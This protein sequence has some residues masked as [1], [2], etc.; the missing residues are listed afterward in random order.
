MIFI[1]L[2]KKIHGES[3]SGGDEIDSIRSFDAQ[4]QRSLENLDEIMIYP[5]AEQPIEKGGLLLLIISK[6]EIRY[7]FWMN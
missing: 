4:S 2:L 6:T 7:S 5:A 1:L 3:S